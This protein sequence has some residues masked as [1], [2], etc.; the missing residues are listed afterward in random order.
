M[1][2]KIILIPT[3]HQCQEDKSKVIRTGPT[4]QVYENPHLEEKRLYRRTRKY[5]INLK[6]ARY[7]IKY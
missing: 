2:Y 6:L 5:Q 7:T 1:K 3:I 4:I